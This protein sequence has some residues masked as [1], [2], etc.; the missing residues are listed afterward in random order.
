M[1]FDSN[2]EEADGSFAEAAVVAE[3]KM[4]SSLP[5]IPDATLDHDAGSNI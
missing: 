3:S 4:A 1:N 5:D 2:N